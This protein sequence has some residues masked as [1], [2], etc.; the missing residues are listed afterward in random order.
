MNHWKSENVSVVLMQNGKEYPVVSQADLEIPKGKITGLIG[1]SG[2]GKS[3]YWKSILGLL[4]PDVWKVRGDV[5]IAGKKI[6]LQKEGDLQKLRGKDVSVILQ[7]PMS[8]F[9]PVFTIE[10]HFMETAAAHLNWKPETVRRKALELLDRLYIQK[11]EAVLK[12]Y[13]FQCSGG[14]LQRIMIAIAL[15][16]E[17][18]V[19]IAD[20]PTTSVDVTVQREILSMLKELNRTQNTSILFISHDLKAVESIA[21][22]VSVMYAGYIVEAFPS[23]VLSAG[24]VSHPYTRKLLEARPSFTKKRLPILAGR[25][26][27]LTERSGGCPFAPRCPEETCECHLFQMEETKVTEDHRIRC[28]LRRKPA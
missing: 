28:L 13:P 8:S 6:E 18:A 16:A 22:Q 4:S 14:M 10:R 3:V 21:H 17:P 12:M 15:M 5:W 25:P 2:C 24:E 26:P 23:G 9:N 27:E 11:P 7:D 19:L 20:E 1:E